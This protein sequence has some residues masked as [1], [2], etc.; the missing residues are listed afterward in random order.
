M[1]YKIE[2]KLDKWSFKVEQENLITRQLRRMI[3]AVNGNNTP[4]ALEY[5]V[6]NV[7]NQDQQVELFPKQSNQT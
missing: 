4:E 1:K 3:V 7:K 6:N 5:F 2:Q